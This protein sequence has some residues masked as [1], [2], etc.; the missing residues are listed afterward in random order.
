MIRG[1]DISNWQ[2]APAL[3]KFQQA[4]AA[5]YQFV[6]IKA[7]EGT[8]RDPT[9][10][11][12]WQYAQQAGLARIA[13]HFAR[14][15]TGATAE[16]VTFALAVR[17][18][19][20][21]SVGDNIAIDAEA[22]SGEVGPYV[23]DLLHQ[24]EQMM[25]LTAGFIYTGN[26]F[27][28][29][30]LDHPPLTEHHL[31]DAVYNS[32]ATFPAAV[33]PWSGQQVVIWQH[34]DNEQVPGF[35]AIDGDLFG[36]TIDQLRALGKGGTTTTTT[37]GDDMGMT[38]DDKKWVARAVIELGLSLGK[39]EG[40][41]TPGLAAQIEGL[42][43]QIVADPEAGISHLIG[44]VLQPDG[45]Y[46]WNVISYYEGVIAQIQADM[47]ALKARLTTDEGPPPAPTTP[48]AAGTAA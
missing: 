18:A 5:G 15:G 40:P 27:I 42:I 41:S 45:A 32:G 22:G 11:G 39:H 48:P 12:N 16:A 21:L 25:G 37:G 9:F 34:A 29:G 44:D 7:S 2:G 17:V 28:G 20:G 4:K 10:A 1:F 33:G 30:H 19:G 26:W 13:Y 46:V 8:W 14:P 24:S 31:W 23:H 43:P 47:T 38:D 35:G 36:G 6:A 3:A